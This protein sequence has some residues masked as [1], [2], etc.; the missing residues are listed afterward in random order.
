VKQ[1]RLEVEP[2]SESRSV[3][4]STNEYANALCPAA[5]LFNLAQDRR[6][7]LGLFGRKV[8]YGA[9]STRINP[10]GWHMR[11]TV[12]LEPQIARKG[13]VLLAAFTTARADLLQSVLVERLADDFKV[14]VSIAAKATI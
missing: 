2:D 9:S 14:E 4:V 6:V 1:R 10:N 7:N 3:L 11:M 5:C 8:T 13:D 12:D